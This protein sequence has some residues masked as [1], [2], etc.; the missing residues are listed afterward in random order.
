MHWSGSWNLDTEFQKKKMFTRV[1]TNALP[2][3]WLFFLS[4]IIIFKTYL[5]TVFIFFSFNKRNDSILMS[6]YIKQMFYF[7][8][9]LSVYISFMKKKKK[10]KN[11]W[12]V[13]LRWERNSAGY[14][15]QPYHM[16]TCSHILMSEYKQIHT[17]AF[18]QSTSSKQS[19]LPHTYSHTQSSQ[20]HINV[21]AS[22]KFTERHGQSE[23]CHPPVRASDNFKVFSLRPLPHALHVQRCRIII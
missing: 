19:P 8:Q 20:A 4:Y 5:L 2:S 7:F 10:K 9:I 1:S 23:T 21:H 12:R 6:N 16:H 15:W 18:K 11:W 13:Y 22:Y 17:E 14:T 3:F